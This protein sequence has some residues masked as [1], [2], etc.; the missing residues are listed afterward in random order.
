MVHVHVVHDV[1][2]HP[3]CMKPLQ[4]RVYT[5]RLIMG[6]RKRRPIYISHHIVI[7]TSHSFWGQHFKSMSSFS[8][9]Y[10]LD[11]AKHSPPTCS[12]NLSFR[13]DVQRDLQCVTKF[14]QTDFEWF[15]EINCYTCTCTCAYCGVT[16]S[17]PI[18]CFNTS[19]SWIQTPHIFRL[20]PI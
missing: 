5:C 8:K 19:C 7:C 11:I 16:R 17:V 20:E 1:H 2:Q 18:I 15:I 4:L 6:R 14:S 13:T 9:M 12:N 10:S 3:S